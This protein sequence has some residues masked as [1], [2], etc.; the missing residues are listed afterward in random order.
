MIN[1]STEIKKT[2]PSL[3]TWTSPVKCVICHYSTSNPDQV[4]MGK[5]R[6]NTERFKNREF[7]VWK[8]PH[9]RSI[10]S[11]EA[12]DYR[13]IYKD[14]PL[15]T[16]QLDIYAYGT[17]GNLLRRLK[18]YGLKKNHT[19]LDYGCGNGVFVQ[20]LK[21]K[22]YAGAV[23]YDPY[24]ADFENFPR[25]VLFD[26]V[27]ANDVIEHVDDPRLIIKSCIDLLK[28]GGLLYLGTSDSEGVEMNDL[29]PHIMRLHQ[30]FHRI[31]MTQE[32]LQDLGTETG[33]ELLAS[34]RRSYM[35]TLMPF[36]NYRFLDEF[37]KSLD[38]IMDRAL[39][40]ASASIVVRKPRLLFY[41]FLGYFFPS[42]FEPAIILRKSIK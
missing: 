31:I 18:K 40:P 6:G 11:L 12:V 9:C 29:P 34:Y 26:C 35:D 1:T 28:P 33:L 14:Y 5:V 24:V 10:H 27:V 21:K 23:G 39:D 22:G 3:G 13:D 37:S 7:D 32:T 8:C 30:P 42:A 16:R 36:A 2:S 41:A 25:N 17:L 19:I 38:H 4:D 20:F 15:N